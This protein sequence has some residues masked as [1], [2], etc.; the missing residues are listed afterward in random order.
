V[1]VGESA[2]VAAETVSPPPIVEPRRREL[3]A[4]MVEM[5]GADFK[6]QAISRAEDIDLFQSAFRADSRR[7][8]SIAG[9]GGPYTVIDSGRHRLVVRLGRGLVAKLE[10]ADPL[11]PSSNRSEARAW[12]VSG[13]L[14]RGMLCPVI[15]YEP[16]DRGSWLLMPECRPVVDELFETAD[17]RG[18]RLTSRLL[19]ET[20]PPA[21]AAFGRCISPDSVWAMNL[22]RLEGRIVVVDYAGATARRL[23]RLE[24]SLLGLD[25][26][27][28]GYVR[29][30]SV[31]VLTEGGPAIRP[32]RQGGGYS[33]VQ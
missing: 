30:S 10:V 15:A 14:A 33:G 29:N 11:R 1:K 26:T 5:L 21:L 25:R 18:P 7:G 24:Q 2:L 19:F 12:S 32:P 27:A 4:R 31:V 28:R 20:G 17:H 23:G 22:G 9:F 6:N 13:P 16:T 3:L 8:F